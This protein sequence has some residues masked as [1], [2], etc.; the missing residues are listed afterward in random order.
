MS[1]EQ[2]LQAISDMMDQK[3]EEKLE[4]KLEEKLDKK[5]DEKLDKK[6]D[7]KLDKKLDEKLDQKLKPIYN[8]LD[9]MEDQYKN[10]Y[11]EFKDFEQNITKSVHTLQDEMETVITILKLNE[12]V[13]Q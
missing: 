2:L 13:P 3:L 1:N 9:N 11:F 7:E 10:F 6:L 4:Q 5:L 8:R 12:L